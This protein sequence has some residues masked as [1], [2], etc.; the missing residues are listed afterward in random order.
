MTQDEEIVRQG[1]KGEKRMHR[2]GLGN[3]EI[4]RYPQQR[5][6]SSPHLLIPQN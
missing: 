1:H 6:S 2:G 5:G 4:R 3:V